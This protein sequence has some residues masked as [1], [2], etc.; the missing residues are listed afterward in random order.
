MPEKAK[1]RI[2]RLDS[3]GGLINEMGRV[4]R[5]ARRGDLD[6]C[7]ASRLVFILRSMRQAIEGQARRISGFLRI[8]DMNEEELL[9]FLGGEPGAEEFGAI[10]GGGPAANGAAKD[11]LL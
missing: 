7:E 10:A 6:T 1:I 5:Q 4:Y 3:V 11:D 8:D 2:S 9:E